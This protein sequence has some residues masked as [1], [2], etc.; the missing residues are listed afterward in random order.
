MVHLRDQ[1]RR[2]T[3]EAWQN[4]PT[5]G[6]FSLL[7]PFLFNR[8]HDEAAYASMAHEILRH[9]V[10]RNPWWPEERGFGSWIQNCVALYPLA[11]LSWLF[12]GNMTAAWCLGVALIGAGWL[13]LFYRVFYWWSQKSEVA[14]PLALFC[15]LFPDV[16]MWLLDIN[17]N[18]RINFE[19]YAAAF[20]Q[21]QANLRPHFYRLPS[22]FLTLFLMCWLFLGVWRLLCEERKRTLPAMV[23][24][25]GVALLAWVHPFEFVFGMATLMVL[26]FAH[27]IW[28]AH[29]ARKWNITAAFLTALPVG[30]FCMGLISHTVNPQ[31]WHEHLELLG[32]EYTRRPYL[33]TAIHLIFAGGGF[34]LFSREKDPK[35]RAA[36]LFLTCAQIAIFLCRNQHVLLGFTVEPFH[37]IPL[38]SLLGA[39]MLYLCLSDWMAS[40]RNWTP[41]AGAVACGVILCWALF[42]E[43]TSAERMYR[44]FGMPQEKEAAFDWARE[45]IPGDALLLSTSMMTNEAIPL[46]TNAQVFGAPLGLITTPFTL[47]AYFK[48]MAVLLKS[49][50]ADAE[51]FIT[52]RWLLPETRHALQAQTV[53]EQ[54]EL[55]E[56]NL[57]NFDAEEWF[58]SFHRD[59]KTF[60][61]VRRRQDEFRKDIEDA[62]PLEGP[63]YVWLDSD[64]ASLLTGPLEKYG[65]ARVFG[66]GAVSIYR[67]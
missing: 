29:A 31:A 24:G 23:L 8:Y 21:H 30:F 50:H 16:N 17:F 53:I 45:N 62:K 49:C 6:R 44:M 55:G 67:F 9:G 61:G 11:G 14:L 60:E 42:N 32:I 7:L 59:F 64:D 57:R 38:G 52:Q 26:F 4:L 15:A 40:S 56:V 36:W 5:N 66:N 46:Y 3:P 35:R 33:I 63:Y 20:F 28:P 37:Y 51:R 65:G 39:L 25:A 34:Y 1:M 10:P 43:K 13:L 27:W 12:D 19:R 41:R 48:K 47:D 58:Y 22:G 2:D 54:H 18:P